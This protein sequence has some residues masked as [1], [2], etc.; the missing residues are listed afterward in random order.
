MGSRDILLIRKPWREEKDIW[1]EPD[2]TCAPESDHFPEDYSFP[3]ALKFSV[4]RARSAPWGDPTQADVVDPVDFDEED[5]RIYSR[6]AGGAVDFDPYLG[7]PPDY[8]DSRDRTSASSDFLGS[9]FPGADVSATRLP[10][11]VA[12]LRPTCGCDVL[13]DDR[14]ARAARYY[15]HDASDE[16]RFQVALFLKT[17]RDWIDGRAGH[18][19]IR[20]LTSGEAGAETACV[21]HVLTGLVRKLLDPP[22]AANVYAPKGV[23]ASMVSGSQGRG[24]LQLPTGKKA[25]GRIEPLKGDAHRKLQGDLSRRASGRRRARGDRARYSWVAGAQCVPRPHRAQ[26]PICRILGW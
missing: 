5:P 10:K 14:V 25:F 12:Q 26:G 18:R 23:A 1:A 15:P 8:G 20:L 11:R 19:P 7:D 21:I 2:G 16:Q 6:Q 4:E 22:G 24:V 17:I 9:D 13:S 3:L